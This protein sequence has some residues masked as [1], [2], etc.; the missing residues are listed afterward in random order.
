MKLFLL[1]V[2][3]N[4]AIFILHKSNTGFQLRRMRQKKK[5]MVSFLGGPQATFKGKVIKINIPI[6][7]LVFNGRFTQSFRVIFFFFLPLVYY[8]K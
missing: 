2:S 4:L 8:N 1:K 7:T 3:L 6:V 5:I